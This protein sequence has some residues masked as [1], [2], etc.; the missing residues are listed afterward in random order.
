V[1]R[2]TSLDVACPACGA[3]PGRTCRRLDTEAPTPPHQPRRRRAAEEQERLNP[4]HVR[5]Q[6][7]LIPLKDVP[8]PPTVFICRRRGRS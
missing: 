6:L 1:R 8:K 2:V 5:G 4:E 7:D 3:Q